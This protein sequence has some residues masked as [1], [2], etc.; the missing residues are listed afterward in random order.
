MRL[1]L[2]AGFDR[3]RHAA[4]LVELLR[5]D[6]HEWVGL[7]V[8]RPFQVSRLRALLRQHGWGFLR[9]ALPRLLGRGGRE[10]SL[11]PF[12]AWLREQAV[13]PAPLS[14]LA[15][16]HGIPLRRVPSL[17]DPA[18]VAFTREAGADGVLYAGGGILENAFLEAA[19]GR[20]LNAH[21]GPLPEIRGM[22]AVEW[23]ILLGVPPAVTI[24]VI[25]R[26]IDT[27]GALERLPI[28]VED[29]DDVE[30]LRAKATQLGVEG[31]RRNVAALG[32]ALP[33]PLPDAGR[34]PQCFVLAPALRE[35]LDQRLA[36][37]AG[38]RP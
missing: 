13:E 16:A 17:N 23:S 5:R 8:V 14:Q 21:S 22:N 6:G 20:V 15:R 28:P 12:E 3:S 38:P 9:R 11:D 32:E 2:T 30:R 4:A 27:G 34:H 37:S 18:A 1:L 10:R 33:A 24:H 29:G 25:E 36:R 35:L 19:G 31:M 7:L 26:G